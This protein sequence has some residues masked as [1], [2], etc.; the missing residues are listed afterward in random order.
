MPMNAPLK[1]LH[2]ITSLDRGGAQTARLRLVQHMDRSRVTSIVGSL[3]DGGSQA[4]E[5]EASGITVMGLGMRRGVPSL[6]AL[7]R[8]RRELGVFANLRPARVWPGLESAGPLKPTV[9][10]GTDL[11]V[12]RELNG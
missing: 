9:L 2:L 7:L 11:M 4:A 5:L 12:V 6:G 10:A 3:L 8:L 1:I